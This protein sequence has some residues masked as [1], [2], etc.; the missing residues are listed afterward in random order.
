MNGKRRKTIKHTKEGENKPWFSNFAEENVIAFTK[1][2]GLCKKTK[3][4][5]TN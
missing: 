1:N 5:N 2:T 4:R 3:T